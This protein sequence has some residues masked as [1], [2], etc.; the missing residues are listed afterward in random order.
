[1]DK[2]QKAQEEKWQA[3]ND[4][5]TLADALAILDD[6]DRLK[7]ARKAAATILETELE[8]AQRNEDRAK[9]L[10]RVAEGKPLENLDLR[11]AFTSKQKPGLKDLYPWPS[12]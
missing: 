7:R 3:E 4:A 5:R 11:K 1:M 10:A 9:A 6:P 2:K 12:L 8:N